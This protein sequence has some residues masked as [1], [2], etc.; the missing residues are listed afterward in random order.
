MF[1]GLV[2]EIGTISKID[3]IDNGFFICIQ[4]NV[5]MNDLHVGDS[6]AVNGICLT[7]TAKTK[8]DLTVEAVGETV[9]RTTLGYWKPGMRTNLERALSANSRI[10]GHFVQGHVDGV[11]RITAIEK[12]DPGY[13]IQIQT[14]ESLNKYLV[15]KG[16]VAVD[17]IS[18]TVAQVGQNSM[19]IAIISHTYDATTLH[20]RR[21]G[22]PVNIEVDILGKYVYHYMNPSQSGDQITEGR[23][24]EWG[25]E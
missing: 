15:E 5:V 17:G 22:D 4:A 7:V 25:F 2:E 24:M 12:R 20:D 10:G 9:S 3:S 11:G 8:H 19:D 13:W 1:T 14:R 6:V 21:S 18:L 23:L 16:S